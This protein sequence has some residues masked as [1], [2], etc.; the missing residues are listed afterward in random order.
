MATIGMLVGYIIL[1]IA[2]QFYF[3]INKL[4]NHDKD[5]LQEDFLIINKKV[6][7]LNTFNVLNSGFNEKEIK[8]LQAQPFVSEVEKV[9]P[10]RYKVQAYTDGNKDFPPFYAEMFFESVPDKFLDID[11]SQWQW[12]TASAYVPV[13]IPRDY[14]KLYNFGF[15]QS[16]N[17]PQISE[18][19]A[20]KALIS[21][22]IEGGGRQIRLKGRIVGFTD[23]INSILVPASFMNWANKKLGRKEKQAQVSRLILVTQNIEDPALARYLEDH[24]YEANTR[25]TK[26]SRLNTL[27]RLL[28]LIVSLI[29]IVII[30]LAVLVFTVSFRLMISRA[31]DTIDKLFLLGYNYKRIARI[32]IRKYAILLGMVLVGSLLIL[33]WLKQILSEHL[34]Q[35]G[36]QVEA[37]INY[38]VIFFGLILSIV[39]LSINAR[40][41]LN[42]FKRRAS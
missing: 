14:L 27:F 34:L 15:A 18:E 22:L 11:K 40:N 36:F 31:S 41:L 32:Y 42:E 21:F 33:W 5:L 1:F 26:P 16:Q 39:L 8:Q 3:D 6:S 12:D 28:L 23:R 13:V 2:I 17:L 4:I 30:F 7:L 35:T 25:Q 24:N 20:S 10:N 19:L 38:R 29:G 9:I 37:G